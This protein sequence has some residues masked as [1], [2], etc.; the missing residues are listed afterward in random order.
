M[1]LPLSSE[2]SE[3]IAAFKRD[4]SAL[5]CSACTLPSFSD[6]LKKI[7][8]AQQTHTKVSGM[9]NR[10][11]FLNDVHSGTQTKKNYKTSTHATLPHPHLQNK[12]K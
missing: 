5:I 12:K 2:D 10:N 3:A 1:S 6:L 7:S 4:S 9:N 8:I 11:L